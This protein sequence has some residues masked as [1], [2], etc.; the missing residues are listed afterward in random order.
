[1]PPPFSILSGDDGSTLARMQDAAVRAD[2]VVSVAS[3]LVPDAV[4]AMVDAARDGAWA[5]ARSLD[6]QLRP[7]FDSLTIR[8]EEETPLGPVTVTSRN[9]VP[10]KSALALVGMPGGACRPPLGRLSPR[11]LERLTGSLAQMHREAP[12]V[13]DP[14]A[15]TFGV[16]L[17]HR[18]SDPAF[19]VGLAYDH[20]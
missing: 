16:D 8:V 19:R 20:Y 4:R 11:G 2:G 9:P 12:S 1:L 15:S 17:A 10:I 7:L 18:L 5:R 14:V 6:A 13:L 3:N